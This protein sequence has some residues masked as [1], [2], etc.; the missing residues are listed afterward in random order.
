V[1]SEDFHHFLTVENARPI[2]SEDEG[3]GYHLRSILLKCYT[4]Q[5]S[6][7]DPS[8]SDGNPMNMFLDDRLH[9]DCPLYCSSGEKIK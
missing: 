3:T 5:V 7:S 4:V 9:G 6:N 2:E 1:S 8:A